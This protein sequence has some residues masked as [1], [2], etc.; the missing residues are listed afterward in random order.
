MPSGPTISTASPRSGFDGC[1]IRCCGSA[2]PREHSRRP[3]WRWTDARLADLRA[4]GIAPIAGL[5]H[6]GS[7]PR[8]TTLLDPDFPEQLAAYARR[9]RRALSVDRRLHP[10]QRAADHRALQRALR[11][12]VS[13]RRDRRG[14]RQRAAAPMQRRPCWPCVRC[15]RSTHPRSWCRPTMR[16]RPSARGRSR[17]RPGSRTIAAGWPGISCSAPWIG[18]IPCGGISDPLERRPASWSGSSTIP[19]RRTSSASTTT[20]RAIGSWTTGAICIPA[21]TAGGNGRDAYVDVEAVRALPR[22]LRTPG[23]F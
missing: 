11:P 23:A 10:D 5:V 9:G 16:A 1:A 4:L 15:A 18:R 2:S 19:V 8:Y 20:S 6:H 7:G 12:L 21:V 3:D 17:I 22:H 13:A 14:L